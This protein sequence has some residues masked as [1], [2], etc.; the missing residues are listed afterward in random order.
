MIPRQ[1]A[2]QMKR[3]RWFILYTLMAPS[4]TCHSKS[5]LFK[6]LMLS[7]VEQQTQY[8]ELCFIAVHSG[9]RKQLSPV[10]TDRLVPRQAS[11]SVGSHKE[12]AWPGKSVK[13]SFERDAR[14][15]IDVMP[16]RLAKYGLTLHPEKTRL[17]DFLPAL[18]RVGARACGLAPHLRDGSAL[19][20]QYPWILVKPP[21]GRVRSPQV[22]AVREP[23]AR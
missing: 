7:Y 10:R 16:K 3:P 13:G 4:L 2:S 23:A 1:A 19:H 20:W 14:R 8:L 22:P 5:F 18:I 17:V 21:P 12:G 9:R 11:S 15:V 6:K